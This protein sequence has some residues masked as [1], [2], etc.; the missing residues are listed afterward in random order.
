MKGFILVAWSIFVAIYIYTRT[1]TKILPVLVQ[2]EVLH[3]WRMIYNQ[4]YYH[5]K[6]KFSWTFSFVHHQ[7]K[8]PQHL[9][10]FFFFQWDDGN[11]GR[12][13]EWRR[14]KLNDKEW[15]NSKKKIMLS[16]TC[17]VYMMIMGRE[18]EETQL[19]PLILT[20]ASFI[21]NIPSC[22]LK[23]LPYGVGAEPNRQHESIRPT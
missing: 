23:Q 10:P 22:P 19:V 2:V 8:M 5:R 20:L 16:N 14:L 12:K 1:W 6:H 21:L 13:R 18:A 15:Y 4:L 7:M 17:F 9:L 11:K 3:H